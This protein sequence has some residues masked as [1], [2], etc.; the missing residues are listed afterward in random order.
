MI[1]RFHSWINR[2]L[3]YKKKNRDCNITFK[4][5]CKPILLIG[6]H[7]YLNDVTIFCW[8]E[9]FSLTIGKYCSIAD[10]VTIIAGGEHHQGWISTYPFIDRWSIRSK[11]VSKPSMSKGNITIG[12]DVWIGN[13]ATILS[14]VSIATGAIIGAGAVVTK[15]PLNNP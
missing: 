8:D 1:N 12:N 13:R 15:S 5:S 4:G 7:S 6:D 9:N 10:D 2:Y 3:L 14:G 11:D